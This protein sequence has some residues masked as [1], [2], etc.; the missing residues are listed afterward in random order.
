MGQSTGLRSLIGTACGIQVFGNETPLYVA[1]D[2]DNRTTLA[3]LIRAFPRVRLL[4]TARDVYCMQLALCGSARPCKANF[5]LKQHEDHIKGRYKCKVRGWL[6]SHTFIN[7]TPFVSRD[8]TMWT[9]VVLAVARSLHLHV[10]AAIIS[11]CRRRPA[12]PR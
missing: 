2:N 8:L 9:S 10:R 1:T 7:R 12:V 4:Y 3:P 5:S 6:G 11:T